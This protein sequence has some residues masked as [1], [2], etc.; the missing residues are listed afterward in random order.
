[1]RHDTLGIPNLSISTALAGEPYTG[2]PSSNWRLQIVICILPLCEDSLDAIREWA[3]DI[4][5]KCKRPIKI[6][7]SVPQKQL[8]EGLSQ[9][10]IN[11]AREVGFHGYFESALTTDDEVDRLF[12]MGLD[13]YYLHQVLD[14]ATITESQVLPLVHSTASTYM[15]LSK[16]SCYPEANPRSSLSELG[17]FASPHV[18][19]LS[20]TLI[21]G[22]PNPSAQSTRGQ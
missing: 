19:E 6:L 3:R 4:E 17:M 20:D 15:P 16:R 8:K 2:V 12:H 21:T 5:M 18:R 22:A 7:A 9:I 14:E 10:F 11:A 13:I 1:M